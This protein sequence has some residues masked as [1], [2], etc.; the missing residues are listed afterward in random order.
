MMGAGG[1]RCVGVAAGAGGSLLGGKG[2]GSEVEAGR[3]ATLSVDPPL[4][5]RPP[6]RTPVQAAPPSDKPR[7]DRLADSSMHVGVWGLEGSE[8][9]ETRESGVDMCVDV[10][11]CVW[12]PGDDGARRDRRR[13]SGQKHAEQIDA[14]REDGTVV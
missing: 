11:V 2:K 6:A 4:G 9:V 3:D 5:W 10:C 14:G 1:E 7:C 13:H 12:C 8:R